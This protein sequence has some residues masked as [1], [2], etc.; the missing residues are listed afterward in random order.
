MTNILIVDDDPETTQLL[1]AILTKEGYHILAINDSRHAALAAE[2]FSPALI[3][4]DLMMPAMDGIATCKALRS[5][6]ALAKTPILFFTAVGDINHK[7][8]AYEAGATDFCTKPI[9]PAELKLKI[10][11]LINKG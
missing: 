4:L 2:H 6:P 10:K 8:A 3:L 11:A 9:H 1:D 5:S 7:V